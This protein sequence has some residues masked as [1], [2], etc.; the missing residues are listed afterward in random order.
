MQL[1]K[2]TGQLRRAREDLLEA[3][4]G[5][6]HCPFLFSA[7]CACSDFVFFTSWKPR[8]LPKC[9]M[10]SVP[11]RCFPD[12][13]WG[14]L[15]TYGPL[16]LYR[17]LIS[18]APVRNYIVQR[19]IFQ[20]Y[21]INLK[22]PSHLE[23]PD[24]SG[25]AVLCERRRRLGSLCDRR[26]WYLQYSLMLRVAKWSAR[27]KRGSCSPSRCEQTACDRHQGSQ[28]RVQGDTVWGTH[29]EYKKWI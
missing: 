4:G 6:Y 11:L 20:S 23:L 19:D 16:V 1:L 10:V 28:S 18:G 5:C 27:P 8:P 3:V 24:I 26:D 29:E 25:K 14:S 9:A 22:L 15:Y 17:Y 13:S 2:N 7:V 21:A 12:S